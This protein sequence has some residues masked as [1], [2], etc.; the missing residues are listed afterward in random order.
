[1][2]RMLLARMGCLLAESSQHWVV[3]TIMSISLLNLVEDCRYFVVSLI[4][5]SWARDV[6]SKVCVENRQKTMDM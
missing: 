6:N 5:Y 3:Q 2:R 1:M 4:C